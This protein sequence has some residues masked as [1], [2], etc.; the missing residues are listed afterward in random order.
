MSTG[1]NEIERIILLM[2]VMRLDIIFLALRSEVLVSTVP[3]DVT[4]APLTVPPV[5]RR[6]KPI[7]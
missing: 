3:Y 2:S 1:N 7:S 4:M 5:S 6:S